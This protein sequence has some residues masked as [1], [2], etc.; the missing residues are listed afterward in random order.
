MPALPM[1]P[2]RPLVP[3]LGVVV[4][5]LVLCGFTEVGA[6]PTSPAVPVDSSLKQIAQT[7]LP[8]S[9]QGMPREF[10]SVD[11]DQYRGEVGRISTSYDFGEGKNLMYKVDVE[12]HRPEGQRLQKSTARYS[13]KDSLGTVQGQTVY[14]RRYGGLG[15]IA[16]VHMAEGPIHTLIVVRSSR[17]TD[18]RRQELP[19]KYRTDLAPPEAILQELD[20]A[21]LHKLSTRFR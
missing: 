6:G 17:R 5:L 13:K 7:V 9:F 20:L 8:T 19:P 14:K 21:R 4:G 2:S 16:S 1:R 11:R 12:Y 3:L 10:V 18:E 15:T